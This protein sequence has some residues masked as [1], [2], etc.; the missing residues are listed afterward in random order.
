[1]EDMLLFDELSI[2]CGATRLYIRE[3]SGTVVTTVML[4]KSSGLMVAVCTWVGWLCFEESAT[5]SIFWKYLTS[6]T[7]EQ[8]LIKSRLKN[9][10]IERVDS[11]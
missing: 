3:V 7:P 4:I 1:M 9:N 11:R 8:A 5:G 10:S 2:S 6:L